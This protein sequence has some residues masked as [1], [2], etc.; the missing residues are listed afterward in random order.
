M[1]N[2]LDTYVQNKPITENKPV[3]TIT[4]ANTVQPQKPVN[5]VVPNQSINKELPNDSF[6]KQDKKEKIK[7]AAKYTAIGAGIAAVA[8]SAFALVKYHGRYLNFGGKLL[9][10]IKVLAAKINPNGFK[11]PVM[12]EENEM[13]YVGYVST[14]LSRLNNVQKKEKYIKHLFETTNFSEESKNQFIRW[15][16]KYLNQ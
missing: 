12:I 7:K 11:P 6:E 10:P 8:Y 4:Q 3:N 1:S 2:L 5:N 14:H 9:E 15:Y 16:G 13:K